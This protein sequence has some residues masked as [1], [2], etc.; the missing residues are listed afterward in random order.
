MLRPLLNKL[1]FGGRF[2]L[3]GLFY[4]GLALVVAGV[5]PETARVY[6]TSN[7]DGENPCGSGYFCCHG[8]CI[9]N[10]YVCCDDGSNGPSSTC[11]C[12]TGCESQC[13]EPST[14]VCEE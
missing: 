10:G 1:S 8:N 5:Q 14:L 11:I 2:W 4:L 7:C 3:A 6:A 12:C 9:P 13:S